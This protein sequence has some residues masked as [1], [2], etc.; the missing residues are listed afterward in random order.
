MQSAGESDD[1]LVMA[2]LPQRGLAGVMTL[3]HGLG[4]RE[5]IAMQS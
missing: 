4:G 3:Q 1:M 5:G 2:A